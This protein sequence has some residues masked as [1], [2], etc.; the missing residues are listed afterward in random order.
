VREFLTCHQERGIGIPKLSP[1]LNESEW[2]TGD[3]AR[4]TKLALPGIWGKITVNGVE[5]DPAKGVPVMTSFS[6]MS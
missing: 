4:L 6:A 5:F 3:P 2:V 1:P